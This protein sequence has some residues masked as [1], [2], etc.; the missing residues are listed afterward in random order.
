[1]EQTQHLSALQHSEQLLVAFFEGGDSNDSQAQ[2]RQATVVGLLSFVACGE[3]FAAQ[4][5]ACIDYERLRI[6]LVILNGAGKPHHC[7]WSGQGQKQK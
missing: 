5:V 3:S 6:G 2:G 1:V 7:A 4:P